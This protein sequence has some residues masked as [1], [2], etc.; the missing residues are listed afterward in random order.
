MT[1]AEGDELRTVDDLAGRLSHYLEEEASS[2]SVAHVHGAGSAAIQSIVA[3][4]LTQELAF[5][6]EVVLTPATG[7]VTRSPDFFY[8]LSA[9]RGVLAEV[10]RGG[11]T[12]NN[13]DLKD[14]WKTHLAPDAHHLFLIVPMS[15]WSASGK[16]RECPFALV[17]RRLGAFFGSHRREVDV[18][19]A[20][21]FGYGSL[22]P[23]AVSD[24]SAGT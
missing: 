12:T 23:P 6:Q 22:T 3:R 7:F 20:H 14:F 16:P 15:N 5:R 4:L 19:S 9:G 2:I 17:S 21:V 11:T 1:P 13:H 8:G 24:D 18:L 10:E